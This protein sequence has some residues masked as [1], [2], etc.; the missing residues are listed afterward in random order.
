M[1]SD[2]LETENVNVVINSINQFRNTQMFNGN[3]PSEGRRNE[4][5]ARIGVLYPLIEADG[6]TNT[7]D[8]TATPNTEWNTMKL[9]IGDTCDEILDS[10]VL[11]ERQLFA[12]RAPTTLPSTAPSLVP[13]ISLGE[14][15]LFK[16]DNPGGIG[17]S[18]YRVHSIAT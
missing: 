11:L 8:A 6:F 15:G 10:W 17:R 7:L 2:N 5:D 4:G 12:C 16:I 1:P 13:S 14:C 18:S 3:D 9:A